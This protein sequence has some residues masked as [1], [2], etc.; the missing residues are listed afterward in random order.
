M[1]LFPDNDDRHRGMYYQNSLVGK[2]IHF[3]IK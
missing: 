1:G 3:Y 2:T